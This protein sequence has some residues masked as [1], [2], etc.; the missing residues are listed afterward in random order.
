MLLQRRL[1][2]RTARLP[3]TCGT[4]LSL[5]SHVGSEVGASCPHI[6]L[7]AARPLFWTTSDRRA[8]TNRGHDEGRDVE[9]MS[10]PSGWMVCVAS[11]HPPGSRLCK[12]ILLIT[13]GFKDVVIWELMRLLNK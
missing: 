5:V 8:R 10:A 2:M 9:Q 3:P 6:G 1:G 13:T 4:V 12:N 7:Q 11:T